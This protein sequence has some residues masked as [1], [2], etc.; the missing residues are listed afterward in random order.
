MTVS[1][2]ALYNIQCI[3]PIWR[4]SLHRMTVYKWD[5]LR[6]ILFSSLRN[7]SFLSDTSF[8]V[9]PE[10]KDF[11]SFS[12]TAVMRMFINVFPGQL[13]WEC[14]KHCL[15]L[16]YTKRL[17][18]NLKCFLIFDECFEEGGGLLTGPIRKVTPPSFFLDMGKMA[19]FKLN[20]LTFLTYLL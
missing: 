18:I 20:S 10:F 5:E 4:R 15:S 8:G 13:W 7:T 2:W 9:S 12:W 1:K 19:M 6:Q 3:F 16:F 11:S 17:F 14:L